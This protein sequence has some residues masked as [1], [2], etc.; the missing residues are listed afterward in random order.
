VEALRTHRNFVSCVRLF[1]WSSWAASAELHCDL[2]LVQSALS[3]QITKL[4]GELSTRL[5]QRSPQ[6]VTPTESAA[7]LLSGSS[8]DPFGTPSKLCVPPKN[9]RLSRAV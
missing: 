7:W 8:V 5:L 2:N 4:E 1:G 6:G 9:R 3:Q